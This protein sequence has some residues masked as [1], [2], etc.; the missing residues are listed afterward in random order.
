M[1]SWT[2]LIKKKKKGVAQNILIFPGTLN[3]IIEI[4]FF[5]KSWGGGGEFDERPTYV[6]SEYHVQVLHVESRKRIS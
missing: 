3:Q 2:E 6:E 5:K 4:C 1:I